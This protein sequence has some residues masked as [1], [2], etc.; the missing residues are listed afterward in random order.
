MNRLLITLFAGAFVMGC[1]EMLPVGMI[2]LIADDL[3]V[4]LAEAGALVTA[5]ALGLAVGGPVLTLATTR[6]DRR[7]VVVGTLVGFMLVTLLPALGASFLPMLVVRV[8]TGALQGLYIAA[9]ITIATA[10]TPPERAGR[11]MS[12]VIA[13]F[14]TASAVGLPLGTLLGQAIGWRGA[15]V[16]VVAVGAAVLVAAL[17]VV[18]SVPA[19]PGARPTGQLRWALA[20]R[21][22]DV[23]AACAV[24]FAGIQAAVTYVV[25]F[26]TEVAGVAGPAVS[27]F[28][29]AYGAA[30]S[31]G[32]LAGGRLAD[33]HA[34]FGLVAGAIGVTASLLALLLLGGH[35]IAAAAAILGIGLFGMGA[36]PSM[37]HRVATLA[38]PGAPLAASLPASAVN[39]GIASG[40]LAGGAALDA[41]GITAAIATG[42]VLAGVA[43][44]LALGTLRLAA[45]STAPLT[46]IAE[47]AR[48]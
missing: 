45:P 47:G 32:S 15:F 31:V 30:T 13:G 16:A 42:A 24:L 48:S 3:R 4:T 34:G 10:T 36:A 29:L 26:L 9:A 17:A 14:A 44:L 2:D 40:A 23:L 39:A 27:I 7:L 21:V 22:L 25:P 38:G 8:V 33:L 43:V 37:Q 5:N 12:V 46:P 20:P 28:L 41:A 18:P 35:P 19:A 11:A 6:L 1:A